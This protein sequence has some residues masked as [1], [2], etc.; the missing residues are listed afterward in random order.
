MAGVYVSNWSTVGKYAEMAASQHG[1]D[2]VVLTIRR[3]LDELSPDPDDAHLGFTTGGVQ[4]ITPYV[5]PSDIVEW[6]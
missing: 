2:P 3:Q 5:P 1:G 4:H 6:Q